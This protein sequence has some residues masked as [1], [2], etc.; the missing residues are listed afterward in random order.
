MEWKWNGNF[1]TREIDAKWK[2]NGMETEWK[3][4]GEIMSSS[5]INIWKW[6]W[7]GMEMEW[8]WN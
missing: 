3:W 2:G 1:A 4:N 5:C 8:K 6:K 7:N